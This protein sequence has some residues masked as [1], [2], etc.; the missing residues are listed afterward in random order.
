MPQVAAR[1]AVRAAVEEALGLE[2]GLLVEFTGLICWRPGACIGWHHDANRWV[3]Q[4][5][6]AI[7]RRMV[8][9][10]QVRAH[11]WTG[12]LMLPLP[13]APAV[14]RTGPAPPFAGPTCA[15]A[16]TQPSATCS[17]QASILA[18]AHFSSS[19]AAAARRGR[20]M[21]WLRPAEW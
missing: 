5:G 4:L 7:C 11:I 13:T 8:G 12:L 20:K 15:S 14:L 6:Q 18:A 3:P 19:R 2:L 10:C 1:E 17:G 21:C 16:H 9:P